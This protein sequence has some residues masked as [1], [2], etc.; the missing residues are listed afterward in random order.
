M[1]DPPIDKFLQKYEYIQFANISNFSEEI[2]EKESLIYLNTHPEISI[3]A[4]AT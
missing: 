4:H 1:K 3:I 2:A